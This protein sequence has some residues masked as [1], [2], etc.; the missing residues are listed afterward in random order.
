MLTSVKLF[1]CLFKTHLITLVQIVCI[2][3]RVHKFWCFM[4]F[5]T[6]FFPFSRIS[7]T[8]LLTM[9]LFPCCLLKFFLGTGLPLGSLVGLLLAYLV[10]KYPRTL[11]S[12][13]ECPRPW[14]RQVFDL[15]ARLS[16]CCFLQFPSLSLFSG[17]VHEKAASPIFCLLRPG[18]LA[19]AWVR[20]YKKVLLHLCK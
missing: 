19:S 4:I 5:G 3:I 10:P 12:S 18:K 7:S 9:A 14:M 15:P 2:I 11:H 6:Y 16:T 13:E 20:F 1:F 17:R 8:A